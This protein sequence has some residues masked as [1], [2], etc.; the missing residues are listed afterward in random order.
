MRAEEC[1]VSRRA[2]A[3]SRCLLEERADLAAARVPL[4]LK[5]LEV[6]EHRLAFGGLREQPIQIEL[7]PTP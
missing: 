4:R 1:E 5:L 7:V 6:A 3:S 2:C